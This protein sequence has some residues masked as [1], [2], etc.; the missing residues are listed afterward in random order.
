MQRQAGVDCVAP[1]D[2]MDGRIG[3]IRAGLRRAGC[4]G[5]LIMSYAAKFHSY[6]YGP[7]RDAAESAP[8]N[9]KLANRATYQ[10][11]PA[12]PGDALASALRDAEEG[13]DILMV[14]PGLPYLDVLQDLSSQITLPW[15]VYQVS[16]ECAAIELMA[17]KGLM[18]RSGA[19]LETWYAFARAGA[20][21]TIS[22]AARS[23]R[24]WI[25]E[26]QR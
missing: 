1:S 9:V 6:F 14:K 11:D 20:N 3:A 13:A 7:F 16:G 10:I 22:Y 19:Y 18:Q 24:Q 23:A 21:M 26:A 4:D 15:A 2:M 25:E 17:E 12:N 8:K 5:A